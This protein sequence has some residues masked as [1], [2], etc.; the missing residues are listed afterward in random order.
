MYNRYY[1]N[2]TPIRMH[3]RKLAIFSLLQEPLWHLRPPH[4]KRFFTCRS[5]PNWC[6]FIDQITVCIMF[7]HIAS[8]IPPIVED[9]APK[10]MSTNSPN[11][12]I[13][14]F[15]QPLMTKLL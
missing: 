5:I 12:L 11:A 14:F 15:C 4:S 1:V 2:M 6:I 13:S 10:D 8:R 3:D 9:L 7:D